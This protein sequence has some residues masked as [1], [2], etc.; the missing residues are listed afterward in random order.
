MTK[1]DE[2]DFKRWRD[3]A[4]GLTCMVVR[5]RHLGTLCGY[6]RVPHSNLRDRL[7]KFERSRVGR[8]WNRPHAV[9]RP[10][11]YDHRSLRHLNAHGGLTFAGRM[12]GVKR[13][14][15]WLGFDCAHHGDLMPELKG[16]I[17]FDHGVYRDFAYVTAQCEGL[18]SQVAKILKKEA[19]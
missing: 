1:P 7:V 16:R 12:T 8:A 9:R 18:A 19:T 15:W 13:E 14:G 3:P 17:G 6:V 11:A 4:T 5:Q 10:C 2:P